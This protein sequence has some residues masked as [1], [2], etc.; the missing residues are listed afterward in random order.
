MIS[1]VRLVSSSPIKPSTRVTQAEAIKSLLT[2]VTAMEFEAVFRSA[3][4]AAEEIMLGAQEGPVFVARA[5]FDTFQR[6][7]NATS[8]GLKFSW[9]PLDEAIGDIWY[10]GDPSSP[11]ERLIIALNSSVEL[12]CRRYRLRP[13]Q[14][15]ATDAELRLP[16]GGGFGPY[17]GIKQPD[18]SWIAGPSNSTSPITAAEIVYGN[19][20]DEAFEREL[21]TWAENGVNAIGIKVFRPRT[22]ATRQELLNACGVIVVLQAAGE[23]RK[24]VWRLGPGSD[25]ILATGHVLEQS[26]HVAVMPASWFAPRA[27]EDQLVFLSLEQLQELL[28]Q[29]CI[30][31][32]DV[33][34]S[35]A[36]NDWLSHNLR[37]RDIYESLVTQMGADDEIPEGSKNAWTALLQEEIGLLQEEIGL[38]QEEIGLLQEEIGLL[39]EEI[40]LM[41][42]EIV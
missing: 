24:S 7:D 31:P 2:P 20:T 22:L 6:L 37:L 12:L 32:Q 36:P 19:E 28:I 29:S 3:T 21:Q 39:Q 16:G 25:I 26:G 33:S 8:S 11:H 5:S 13:V 4:R 15:G 34:D 41:Q 18:S 14:N 35:T 27:T 38:L 1:S 23:S 9:E 42:E 17:R 10:Y 40:V 30:E